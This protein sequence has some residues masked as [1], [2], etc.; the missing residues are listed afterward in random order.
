MILFLFKKIQNREFWITVAWIPCEFKGSV[1]THRLINYTEHIK[2]PSTLQSFL[3]KF[4]LN[5]S[6]IKPYCPETIP[7]S[8]EGEKVLQ[9]KL[10]V[11]TVKNAMHMSALECYL[12]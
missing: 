3:N 2:T 6:I 7:V 1:E 5:S 4:K 9:E 8:L 11:V 10:L 12:I